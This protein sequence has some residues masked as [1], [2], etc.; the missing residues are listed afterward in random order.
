MTDHV[1]PLAYGADY[2]PEQWPEETWAEDARL[3]REAGVNLVSLGI[4]AWGLLEPEPGVYDFGLLDKVIP[5]LADAGVDV[6]LATPTAAP[7]NWFL[8]RYPHVRPVHG[9]RRGARRLL[10]ADVLPALPRVPRGLRRA[11]RPCWPNATPRTP[12]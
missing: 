4:F 7:P 2:N 8:A 9:G 11:S 1:R 3:M 10:A 5:L 12:R 6:D